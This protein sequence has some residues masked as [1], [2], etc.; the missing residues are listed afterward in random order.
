M[1]TLA[2]PTTQQQGPDLVGQATDHLLPG[3][4]EQWPR[5]TLTGVLPWF[6]A[7]RPD[8]SRA[9]NHSGITKKNCL[10]VTERPHS[11]VNNY[12]F[13]PDS[14][15]IKINL[16]NTILALETFCP[17]VIFISFQYCFRCFRQSCTTPRIYFS[18]TGMDCGL[19]TH[20]IIHG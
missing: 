19:T 16:N 5:Q 3:V 12:L 7:L 11:A 8:G 18:G 6:L 1:E 20:Q 13:L 9:P 15:P 10:P 17:S 4:L 2:D 14:Q